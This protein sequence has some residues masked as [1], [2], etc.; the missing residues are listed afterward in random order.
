[1]A[2]ANER[3]CVM[4]FFNDGST[5]NSGR[6]YKLA[7]GPVV[8]TNTKK[9]RRYMA[10]NAIPMEDDPLLAMAEDYADGLHQLE[11]TLGITGVTETVVRA[12]I[13]GY[14]T[15]ENETGLAKQAKQTASDTLQ[16]EDLA[17]TEF[18][19]AV[20]GVLVGFLGTRWSADWEPTGFPDE[21]TRVPGTQEKRMNLCAAL[22]T[23]FTANP[24]REFAALNVTAAKAQEHYA[25]LSDG[26]Q[27]L[28]QKTTAQGQKLK[29][30]DAALQEIRKILHHGM[31]GL[32]RLLANDD[33]RWHTFGLSAP[34]D[35]ATP[36][37]VVSLALRVISATEIL[38]SWAHPPRA[39][40]YRPFVQIV[41]VDP[42]PIARESVDGLEV[43]LG[44]FAAG[45]TVKV[46]I[47]AANDDGEGNPSPTEE[48][49]I[50]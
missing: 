30:R 37:P 12:A 47:V 15:A 16:A 5:Y 19:G 23:Y 44:G 10:G 1:M 29:A 48:I 18:L 6:R 20:R 21:S 41:G 49:L 24:T 36:E 39:T 31:A 26:R 33:D 4:P 28:L 7:V 13:T 50:T 3:S 25:A 40:R 35:P 27:A 43:V 34:D 38:A 42:E 46:F 14:H 32:P 9:G 2:D 45:Q 11:A 22:T 8:I 17:A